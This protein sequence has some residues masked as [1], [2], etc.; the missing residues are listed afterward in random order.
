MHLRNVSDVQPTRTEHGETIYETVGH[1]AGGAA[2]HSLAQIVLAPGCASLKHFHPVAEETYHILS[3]TG[4]VEIDGLRSPVRAGD[5]L[6][7]AP[8]AEHQIANTGADDLT[9]LAICVPAWT[10]DNSVFLDK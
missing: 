4:E 8:G 3:G 2:S 9:F 5:S 1:S 7:I 10:P 6:S